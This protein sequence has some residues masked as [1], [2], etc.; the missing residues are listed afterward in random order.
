[1]TYAPERVVHLVATFHLH[2]WDPWV[3][4][5]RSLLISPFA[6]SDL[7]FAYSFT[8]E[9]K[10]IVLPKRRRVLSWHGLTAQKIRA[11]HTYPS[12]NI[13]SNNVCSFRLMHHRLGIPTS[14][15]PPA[16]PL[17]WGKKF[18]YKRFVWQKREGCCFLNPPRF[19]IPFPH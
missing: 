9:L 2:F 19:I 4:Q 6:S 7:Y 8:L 18:F 15:T 11:P 1:M 5:A 10:V 13:K 16:K 12:E 17:W 3:S 14:T